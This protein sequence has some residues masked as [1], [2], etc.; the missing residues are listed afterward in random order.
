M[1]ETP[2][3]P[4][5]RARRS[6]TVRGTEGEEGRRLCARQLLKDAAARGA[7]LSDLRN[8]PLT[9]EGNGL[10]SWQVPDPAPARSS[11]SVLILLCTQP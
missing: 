6:Q 2:S 10:S 4:E 5:P 3:Q 7:Q 1:L 8:L 9:L 11:S